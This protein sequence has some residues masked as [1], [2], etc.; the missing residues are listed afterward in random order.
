LFKQLLPEKVFCPMQD[1]QETQYWAACMEEAWELMQRLLDYPVE[2]CGEPMVMLPGLAR[3]QGVPMEFPAG[4][5]RGL[6]PRLFALR[7]SL[8]EPLFRVA[9]AMVRRGWLLRVED[10]YRPLAVQGQGATSDFV[11]GTALG[12][13]RWELGG[14]WPTP[15]FLYRRLACWTAIVPKFAN[16]TSGSALDVTVLELDTGIEVDRGGV[17]PEFSV[18]TPMDSP[19]IGARA[20]RN[21]QEANEM[22]AAEGFLPYPFEFWH[23]SWGDA[24]AELAMGGKRPGRYGPVHWDPATGDLAV[25]EDVLRPLLTVEQV[26]AWLERHPENNKKRPAV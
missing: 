13:V 19:F 16:H 23:Y 24:D 8:V 10:A 4:K 22:F 3:E 17:Y 20:K 21:R 15:E 1:R 11:L 7:E 26:A 6:F 2:E 12:Q 5:K 25:E 14:A 18:R 9:K